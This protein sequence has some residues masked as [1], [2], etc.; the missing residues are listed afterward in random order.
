SNAEGSTHSNAVFLSVMYS[1]VCLVESGVTVGTSKG[2]SVAL[3]CAV[4]AN[5]TAFRF[6][7]E[8]HGAGDNVDV[9]PNGKTVSQG[10][11]SRFF[12]TPNADS[13]FGTFL[14]WGSN[15]I[16]RQVQPCVFH[17]VA[18]GWFSIHF[19]FHVSNF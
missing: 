3:R 19:S 10:D 14:C 6:E 2:E 16:G 17:V 11:L 12:Y 7:W 13:E 4:E 1:P 15:D 8:F 5:P 9:V 18:A